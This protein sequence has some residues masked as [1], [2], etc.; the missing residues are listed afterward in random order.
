MNKFL[1]FLFTL[2]LVVFVLVWAFKQILPINHTLDASNK[3]E[4]VMQFIEDSYVDTV[5]K[6]ELIKAAINGTLQYL[7]DKR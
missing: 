2:L 7:E 6:D 3:I 4:S 1:K 5:N